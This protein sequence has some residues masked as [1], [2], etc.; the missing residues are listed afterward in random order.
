MVLAVVNL[1]A[2]EG[3]LEFAVHAAVVSHGASAI[4][5][6]ADSGG[7]KSTLAA[8]AVLCGL[9]YLSDE[10]LVLND[11][12]KVLPY[13]KPIALSTWSC[14]I[15]GI[16]SKRATKTLVTPQELGGVVR[17]SEARLTDVIV[18]SYGEDRALLERRPNSEAVTALLGK[19]FNHYKDPARAFRLATNA[20]RRVRMWRL[21][22]S[23]PMEAAHLLSD[24]LV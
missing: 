24:R 14:S 20:A 16:P 6:P 19:S 11:Q 9:S 5:L 23:D 1:A 3:S 7:G 2:I 18:P 21:R 15:L 12:G 22:Y 10:A 17:R 8:A 4:A 13:P